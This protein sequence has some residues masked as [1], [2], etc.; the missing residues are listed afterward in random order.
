MKAIV[1][2]A[3]LSEEVV[4]KEIKKKYSIIAFCDNDMNKWGGNGRTSNNKSGCYI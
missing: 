1:F 3:T 4:Y 2:G